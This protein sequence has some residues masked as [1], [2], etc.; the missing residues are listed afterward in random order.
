MTA[1][2]SLRSLAD[3]GLALDHRGDR[4][5]V[6]D[7]EVLGARVAHV[8]ALDP[9]LEVLELELDQVGDRARAASSSKV[10]GKRKPSRF[11]APLPP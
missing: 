2:T 11:L 9:P 5:H 6:V 8:D 10:S 4:H 1:A 3:L 7:G